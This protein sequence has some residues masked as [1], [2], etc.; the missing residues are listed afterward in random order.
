MYQR[1]KGKE[2]KCMCAYVCYCMTRDRI[3]ERINTVI[4]CLTR[5]DDVK[6]YTQHYDKIISRLI[7]FL[8]QYKLILIMLNNI[9]FKQ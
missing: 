8:I 3:V 7:P 5:C 4:I 2:R 1:T 6:Y 9:L